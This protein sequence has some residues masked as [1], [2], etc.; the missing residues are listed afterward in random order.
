MGSVSPQG[1]FESRRIL[2]AA[3]CEHCVASQ[4]PLV[5]SPLSNTKEFTKATAIVIEVK[6]RR[7][8][9]PRK[10]LHGLARVGSRY[11]P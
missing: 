9:H 11:G 2:P 1:T 3:P 7:S 4:N 5:I 6:V 8:N 10:A